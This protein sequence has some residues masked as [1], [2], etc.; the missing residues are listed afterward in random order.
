MKEKKKFEETVEQ[1]T[2]ET[3]PETEETVENTEETVEETAENTEEA[4]AETGEVVDA[5]PTESE[6]NAELV[7]Q[8]KRL[9]A[10]FDNYRKR[11]DKEKAAQYDMGFEKAVE[12]LLPVV[13]DFERGLNAVPEEERTGKVYEGM[14][15]IYKKMMKT[16][17]DMG[18]EP[19]AAEGKEF[20]PNLHNAVLQV[21]N[22]D[23]GE[24]VVV[25]ELQKGYTY[26]GN[27]IRH[28]MVSVNK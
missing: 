7:D 15:M 6:R 3:A 9:L 18:V 1:E 27:V 24:N 5:T 19:I 12:K 4:T 22:E 25:A 23:Y 10:E 20:D 13:D 14:D 21:E 2:K 16:L 26:K 28:S 11:T 8:N 17:T